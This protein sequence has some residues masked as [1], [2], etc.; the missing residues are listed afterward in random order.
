MDDVFTQIYHENG[1]KNNESRSGHGSTTQA[2]EIIR[3]KLPEILNELSIKSMLDI[4]CGDMNW[5]SEVALPSGLKYIGADIVPDIIMDVRKKYSLANVSFE[6]LDITKDRLPK[7]DLIFCR[8]LLGH[9]TSAEVLHAVLKMKHS[10]SK[11]LLAT[12]FPLKNSDLGDIET[13]QW[14]PIN[15]EAMR[16]GLGPAQRMIAEGA[17]KHGFEDKSLGLWRLKR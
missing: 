3:E 14:R 11:W 10:R 15:L 6:V 17:T 12:T 9:L 16:F 7:V 13:G 2:T 4:P 5:M 8:D 1:W